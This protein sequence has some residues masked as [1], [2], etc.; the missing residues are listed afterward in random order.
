MASL[1]SKESGSLKAIRNS[2]NEASSGSSVLTSMPRRF[3]ITFRACT[4]SFYALCLLFVTSRV[5]LLGTNSSSSIS[6]A[7]DD[8]VVQG[9]GGIERTGYD[10]DFLKVSTK[11]SIGKVCANVT[12]DHG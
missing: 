10:S 5:L 1:V 8:R 12:L 9:R 4:S 6:H 2:S 3:I 11:T 7:I